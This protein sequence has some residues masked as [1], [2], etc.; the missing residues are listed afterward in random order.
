MKRKTNY[1]VA[2]RK[3]DLR[4]FLKFLKSKF[5]NDKETNVVFI[6]NRYAFKTG[7]TAKTITSW[8]RELVN[9]ELI[10]ETEKDIIKEIKI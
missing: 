10:I 1:F 6:V 9:A 2:K 4:D 7:F 5:E 8:Y 3:E